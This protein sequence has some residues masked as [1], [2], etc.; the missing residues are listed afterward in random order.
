MGRI[1]VT[2]EAADVWMQLCLGTASHN[3]PVVSASFAP[4]TK[5]LSNDETQIT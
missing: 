3:N 1:Q 2:L 4:G 5:T